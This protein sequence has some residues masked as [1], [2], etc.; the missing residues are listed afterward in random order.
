MTFMSKRNDGFLLVVVVIS[1]SKR[2]LSDTLYKKDPD[3][4]LVEQTITLFKN[5]IPWDFQ[6]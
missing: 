4:A 5:E 6:E 2:L 3:L 1:P